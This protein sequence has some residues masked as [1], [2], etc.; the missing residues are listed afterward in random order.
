MTT[1]FVLNLAAC[2][3]SFAFAD[4]LKKAAFDSLTYYNDNDTVKGQQIKLTWNALQS[5]V[6]KYYF[7]TIN[8]ITFCFLA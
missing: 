5:S 2:I 1:I 3:L 8:L 6:S 7:L 4:T